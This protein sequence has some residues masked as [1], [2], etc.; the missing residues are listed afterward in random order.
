MKKIKNVLVF[1]FCSL[2][3]FAA[4]AGCKVNIFYVNGIMNKPYEADKN[5][6]GIKNYFGNFNYT[7][8]QKVL[9]NKSH[10]FVI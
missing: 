9:Y 4:H 6:E 10:N 8:Y 2:I 1:C 3:I 7:C 5:F